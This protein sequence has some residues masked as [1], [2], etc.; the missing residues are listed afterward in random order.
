[1]ATTAQHDGIRSLGLA[2]NEAKAAE[3]AEILKGIA[4]PLRLRIVA[5]LCE[6]PMT[7]TEM[8][9]RLGVKQTLV[10][11]HLAPLR[12]LGLVTVERTA[13]MARYTIREEGL[14]GLV[15]CL[16]GCKRG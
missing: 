8:Y 15:G 3:L 5:A 11:Q 7:V 9:Q 6:G 16:N 2:D 1:M 12:L 13:S 10:S 4:H 14:K